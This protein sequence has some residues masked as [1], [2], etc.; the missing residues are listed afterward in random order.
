MQHGQVVADRTS[1]QAEFAYQLAGAGGSVQ[2]DEQPG[3]GAAEQCTKGGALVRGFCG[4]PQGGGAPGGVDQRLGHR[5]VR[6]A[7]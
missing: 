2:G 1:C 5:E 4:F 7:A 6:G 3:A